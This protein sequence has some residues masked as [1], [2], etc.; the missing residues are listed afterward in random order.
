MVPG[1]VFVPC[2]EDDT[3]AD[4]P[5]TFRAWLKARFVHNGTT[6]QKLLA[7][8]TFRAWLKARK[9]RKGLVLHMT[10]WKW[11]RRSA[12]ADEA[13]DAKIDSPVSD[14][15]KQMSIA[16]AVDRTQSGHAADQ[17]QED[18]KV[19]SEEADSD[20]VVISETEEDDATEMHPTQI[21]Y[22]DGGG[23]E[24]EASEPVSPF[25]DDEAREAQCAREAEARNWPPDDM[26]MA[27]TGVQHLYM[28]EP[29]HRD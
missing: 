25:D 27:V 16:D 23:S 12:D 28:R 24:A 10:R 8:S 13:E 17:L 29:E 3:S 21:E 4:E 9:A 22:D 1:A 26:W 15:D 6:R 20:G 18:D 11:P 5:S 14:A 19:Q 7:S 2:V